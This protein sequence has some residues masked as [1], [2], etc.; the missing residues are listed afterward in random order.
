[1]I[2]VPM[3]PA[4]PVGFV[5][6]RSPVDGIL[7]WGVDV[8]VWMQQASPSLDGLFKAL[9]FFGSEEFYLLLLP[10]VYW[11]V[12]RV[13]GIRLIVLLL[14]SAAINTV[15]KIAAAQPR[16]F[17]Y[18]ARVKP[19]TTETTYGFPS[20]HTQSTTS[21]WGFL[22]RRERRWWFWALA[23]VMVIGVGTSRIYLGVHFPT[24]VLGGLVIGLIVLWLFVKLWPP[25]EGWLRSLALPA[26]LA[27]TALV[28]LLLLI[29]SRDDEVVTGVGTMVGIGVGIALERRVVRFSTSG[30]IADKALRLAVGLV[31]I[32]GIWAGLRSLFAGLEPAVLL[33][34]LRY[35]LVGA[36]ASLGAPW[37]FVRVGIAGHRPA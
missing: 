29:V 17:Q 8:V 23:I 20:G 31:V 33:R 37:L 4:L 1:M 32:V 3:V 30:T 22:G 5:G 27:F 9:T 2:S 26:Q 36:W 35:F 21:V 28:P 12:D 24:D 14:S 25:I 34:L 13:L 15:A 19:I 18:D 7:R 6:E 16:P 10:F 11:C